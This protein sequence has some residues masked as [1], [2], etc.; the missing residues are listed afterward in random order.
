MKN[1]IRE[2]VWLLTAI[3][4]LITGIYQTYNEGITQS[5]VFFLFTIF[6][7]VLFIIRRNM[8]KKTTTQQNQ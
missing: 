6:A 8:G 2:T 4:C 7:F 5:W 1:K 3:M